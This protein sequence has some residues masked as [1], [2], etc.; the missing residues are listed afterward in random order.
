MTRGSGHTLGVREQA[1]KAGP[2][3]LALG[4]QGATHSGCGGRGG[5]KGYDRPGYIRRGG[6]GSGTQEMAL[7]VAGLTQEA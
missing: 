3:G 4:D 7:G 1:G 2:R 6:P 5:C